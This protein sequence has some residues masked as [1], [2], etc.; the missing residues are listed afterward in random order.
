M[1][2]NSDGI[3]TGWQDEDKKTVDASTTYKGYKNLNL[4]AV[5]GSA[6]VTIVNANDYAIN[7]GW[8]SITDK[9]SND[10]TITNNAATAAAGNTTVSFTL[11]S[12]SDTW[13]YKSLEIEIK[14]NDGT[15]VVRKSFNITRGTAVSVSDYLSSGIYQVSLVGTYGN[16]TNSF[17]ITLTVTN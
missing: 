12:G 11:P 17:V 15:S 3:Y 1:N 9:D 5:G 8:V 7:A 13:V 4:F 14:R 16:I 2:A 6:S 10:V